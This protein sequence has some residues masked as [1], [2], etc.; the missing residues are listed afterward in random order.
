MNWAAAL[1]GPR[2]EQFRTTRLWLRRCLADLSGVE[3]DQVPLLAPPG[4][5]PRLAD[6]WGWISLSHCPDAV[7]VAWSTE[8]VGV[9][10][11]RMDRAVP[12]GPLAQRFFCVPDRCGLVD[13]DAEAL[14]REVLNQWVAKEAAIKWQ[15]GSLGEGPGALVLFGEFNQGQSSR[16]CRGCAGGSLRR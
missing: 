1:T 3:P 7:A 16:C 14:R 5:P 9:D 11:E 15:R 2:A 13:L 4:S 12:A 6:G 8:R 10:L